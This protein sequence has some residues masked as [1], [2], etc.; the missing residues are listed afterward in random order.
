MFKF[1]HK[2][3]DADCQKQKINQSMSLI[4]CTLNIVQRIH[5]DRQVQ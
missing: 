3:A 4:A 1:I 5:Q 2:Y